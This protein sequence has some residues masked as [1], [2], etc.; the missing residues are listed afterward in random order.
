MLEAN[1]KN[2]MENITETNK[3]KHNGKY[4]KNKQ[5]MMHDLMGTVKT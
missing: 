1:G 4:H 5:K 2:I 3:E